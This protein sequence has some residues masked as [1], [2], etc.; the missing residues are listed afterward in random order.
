VR[1]IVIAVLGTISVLVLVFSFDAS[2]RA[3]EAEVYV[4][5]ATTPTTE[6]A[7]PSG[8]SQPSSASSTGEGS[9]S[10]TFTGAEAETEHGVVQVRIVV[11]NGRIVAAKAVQ[12]PQENHRDIEINSWAIPQLEQATVVNSGQFDSYSGATATCDGYRRSLQSALDQA[13]L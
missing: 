9:V 5:S 12:Y 1:K 13:H 2:R 11:R 7:S 3:E 10:G 6:A 4:V 8:P